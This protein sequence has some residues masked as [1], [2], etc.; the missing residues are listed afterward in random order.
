V[1]PQPGT[2][3]RGTI[4]TSPKRT[5]T[6]FRAWPQLTHHIIGMRDGAVTV[7]TFKVID[8]GIVV[9]A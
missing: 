4:R 6:G 7:E 3:T 2:R 1:R 9:K 8:D 5:W